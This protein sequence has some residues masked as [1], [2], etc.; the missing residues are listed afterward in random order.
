MPGLAEASTQATIMAASATVEVTQIQA[1]QSGPASVDPSLKKLKKRL[2]RSGYK[3][4][5]VAARS[6]QPISEGGTAQFAMQGGGTI[7]LHSQLTP[8]Y[9][10]RQSQPRVS[11]R[12]HL[13]QHRLHRS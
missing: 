8:V 4:F 11:S 13:R 12:T 2:E 3:R 7:R 6:N 1:S 5:A 10:L 9:H